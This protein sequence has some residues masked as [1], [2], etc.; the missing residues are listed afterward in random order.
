MCRFRVGKK[1]F[2]RS[3]KSLRGLLAGE[4]SAAI[5]VRRPFRRNCAGTAANGGAAPDR[6]NETDG[7]DHFGAGGNMT[8]N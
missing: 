8:P 1:A 3:A 6:A 4:L 2:F 5:S 7:A